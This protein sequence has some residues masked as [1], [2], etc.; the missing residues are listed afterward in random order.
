MR[1]QQDSP[2]G[3]PMV[4]QLSVLIN[5]WSSHRFQLAHASRLHNERDFTANRLLYLLGSNGPMRPSELATELGS[6]RANV[7]KVVARLQADG[8]VSR[9][10]DPMDSRAR[11]VGLTERGRAV[12]IDIFRIG[13]EM[14]Q[15]LTENWSE[16]ERQTFTELLGRLNQATDVYERRLS[17]ARNVHSVESHS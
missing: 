4:S 3:A 2:F 11:L 14:V 12:S 17:A 9:T 6:G 1:Q 16:S 13:D 15:E 10:A 8:L 7:S 5:R